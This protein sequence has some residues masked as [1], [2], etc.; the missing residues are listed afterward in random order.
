MTFLCRKSHSKLFGIL[1][2]NLKRSQQLP[3]NNR[4]T[5]NSQLRKRNNLIPYISL[6]LNNEPT[7]D[8]QRTIQS[9]VLAQLKVVHRE[10]QLSINQNVCTFTRSLGF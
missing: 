2:N 4:I 3:I 6:G 8:T 10:S 1:L 5:K 7:G 9:E